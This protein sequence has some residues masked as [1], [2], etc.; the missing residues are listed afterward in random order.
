[1]VW[2]EIPLETYIWLESTE[3]KSFGI[4]W[5]K[6]PNT[7]RFQGGGEGGGDWHW[8]PVE[9]R[10]YCATSE[11]RKVEYSYCESVD[12]IDCAQLKVSEGWIPLSTMTNRTHYTSNGYP[13]SQSIIQPF[14]RWAE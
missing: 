8:Q 1:M 2:D 10:C 14:W 11:R 6:T 5:F 13:Y 9:A 7:L 3:S 12:I 4:Q